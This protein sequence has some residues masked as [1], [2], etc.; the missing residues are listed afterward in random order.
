MLLCVTCG[1]SAQLQFGV[2]AGVNVTSM[3]FSRK[4]VSASNR[5]GFYVG[6]TMRYTTRRTGLGFDVSLLYDQRQGE[7]VSYDNKAPNGRYESYAGSVREQQITVPIN[8]RWDWCFGD[9]LGIFLYLGPEYDFN[10]GKDIDAYDWRWQTSHWSAN[11]GAG[12]M[13]INHLQ[14]QFNYNWSVGRGGRFDNHP[15]YEY[16]KGR[17]NAWQVGIAYYI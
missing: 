2:K 7:A 12:I 10:V 11:F 16:A 14:I 4:D 9:V 13:L 1:V 3:S 15:S 8:L 17:F 5:T 6:P